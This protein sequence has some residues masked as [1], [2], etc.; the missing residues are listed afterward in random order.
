[1]PSLHQTE[2]EGQIA[3][4]L[5]G[6]WPQSVHAVGRSAIYRPGSRK[7]HVEVDLVILLEKALCMAGK[8]KIYLHGML[9]LGLNILTRIPGT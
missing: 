1:M 4:Q 9:N 2:N 3:T 6:Q 8:G 7:A 5:K